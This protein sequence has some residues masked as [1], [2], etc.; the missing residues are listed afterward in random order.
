[1]SV[2]CVSCYTTGSGSVIVPALKANNEALQI[3][4]DIGEALLA[5]ISPLAAIAVAVSGGLN[6]TLSDFSAHFE[7]DIALAAEGVYEYTV[8]AIGIPGLGVDFIGNEIGVQLTL[9]IV[10]DVKGSIDFTAGFDVNF[11]NDTYIEMNIIE[12][13]LVKTN[14]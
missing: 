11:P 5:L 13:E 4:E 7:F 1:M 14:L 8:F 3:L 10:F 2:T 6:I 12:G 9:S